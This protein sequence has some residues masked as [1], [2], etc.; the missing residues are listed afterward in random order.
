MK[1]SPTVINNT[2]IP[3]RTKTLTVPDSIKFKNNTCPRPQLDDRNN[4]PIGKVKKFSSPIGSPTKVNFNYTCKMQKLENILKKF[5]YSP[6][7]FI[8]CRAVNS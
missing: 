8:A 1:N 5:F 4:T 6:E 7:C 3:V 2:A